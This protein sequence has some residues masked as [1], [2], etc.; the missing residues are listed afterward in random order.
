MF[1]S[2]KYLLS[3]KQVMLKMQMEVFFQYLLLFDFIRNWNILKFLDGM[4]LRGKY[5]VLGVLTVSEDT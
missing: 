3:Y 1:S 4:F 5:L 2:N